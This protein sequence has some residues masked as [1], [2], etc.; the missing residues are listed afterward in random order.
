MQTP[1]HLGLVPPDTPTSPQPPQCTPSSSLPNPHA[2]VP[3]LGT[4]LCHRGGGTASPG[5]DNKPPSPAGGFIRGGGV[6][7]TA[8]RTEPPPTSSHR[9][10]DHLG[11]GLEGTLVPS[12]LYVPTHHVPMCCHPLPVPGHPCVPPRARS[13]LVPAVAP[14]LVTHRGRAHRDSHNSAGVP[15]GR[16][17]GPHG[18]SA[19]TRGQTPRQRGGALP[20]PLGKTQPGGPNTTAAAA[21]N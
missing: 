14:P 6:P 15:D 1:P 2:A 7:P 10:W 13:V 4:I 21:I 3:A 16:H 8:N 5:R 11:T 18:D 20:H 9:C 12:V 17:V 19:E